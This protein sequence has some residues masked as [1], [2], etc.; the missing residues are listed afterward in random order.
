MPDSVLIQTGLRL[1]LIWDLHTVI[2]VG[3]CNEPLISTAWRLVPST[4]PIAEVQTISSS[5]SSSDEVEVGAGPGDDGDTESEHTS[6]N[7]EKEIGVEGT[8]SD[9]SEGETGAGGDRGGSSKVKSKKK[10]PSKGTGKITITDTDSKW[11]K[12]LPENFPIHKDCRD[13][14]VLRADV[15]I[16][17]S[18]ATINIRNRSLGRNRHPSLSAQHLINNVNKMDNGAMRRY[19]GVENFLVHQGLVNEDRC[20]YTGSIEEDGCAHARPQAEE[21]SNQNQTPRKNKEKHINEKDLIRLVAQRP[22]MVEMKAY[23]SLLR[24]KGNGIYRG[25]VRKDQQSINRHALLLAGYGT[26][27]DGIHYWIVK[28]SYGLDWGEG[29]YGKIIRQC[30]PGNPNASSLFA[31]IRYAE[32]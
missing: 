14:G 9:S 26:T 7:K 23:T 32:I 21:V 25:K 11:P 4:E 8:T 1:G 18:N 28:N 17:G 27:E 30:S 2:S 16:Q 10:K 12:D 24:F 5:S 19:E 13:D 22:V 20:P 31:K 6:S 3:F 29:G 15:T